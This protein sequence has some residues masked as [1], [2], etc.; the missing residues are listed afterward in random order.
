MQGK[1]L[2]PRLIPPLAFWIVIIIFTL[3]VPR[4]IS[5]IKPPPKEISYSA[6]KTALTDG[7]IR[8]VLVSETA[9]SGDML[10]DTKFTT[11]RVTDPDLTSLMEAQKVEISGQ[12]DDSN[13][14]IFG[15][16]FI[17]VLPIVVMAGLWFWL[18]RRS[19][20]ADGEQ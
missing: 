20:S 6:F 9:I 11:V 8:S 10:D 16:L 7:N 17:W 3:L 2:K 15:I 4:I 14:G 12:V 1:P 19:S 5:F 13:G 18:M